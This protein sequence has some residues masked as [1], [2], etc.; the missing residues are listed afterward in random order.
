M[1]NQKEFAHVDDER[2]SREFLYLH[3]PQF[4]LFTVEVTSVRD[5][6]HEGSEFSIGRL[7]F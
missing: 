6:N 2:G 3:L 7:T 4:V 5:R 1:N